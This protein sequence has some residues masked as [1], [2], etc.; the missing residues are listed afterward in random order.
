MTEGKDDVF[1]RCEY[2]RVVAWP[3]RIRRE[4]PFLRAM[5]GDAPARSLLDAGCGT[6]EHARHFAEQGWRVVGVDQAESMIAQA[7]ELAGAFPG[8][9]SV[10]YD[11]R[12]AADAG[13]LPDAPFGAAICLGNTLAFVESEADLRAFFAGIA[14]ALCPGGRLL[15]QMLNYERI[16]GVPVRALPLNVTALPEEEGEGD[17]IFARVFRPKGD[18]TIAFY[19]FTLSLEPGKDPMV[20]VRHAKETVHWAWKRP[21]V[22]AALR[23]A[24]FEE[25]RA[26]GNMADVPYEAMG[27]SDLVLGAVRA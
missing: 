17:L 27:S 26:F 9:G 23:A 4:W 3:E 13:A 12:G 16:E 20:R 11:R 24:G 1:S 15:L 5:L 14:A 25:L 8:G 18:G 22:E 6:G 7:S 2:R 19:P 21:Q 10:R